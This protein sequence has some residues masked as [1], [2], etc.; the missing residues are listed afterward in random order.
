MNESSTRKGCM[1][2]RL[3]RTQKVMAKDC[4][5]S[6]QKRRA[7]YYSG[8]RGEVSLLFILLLLFLPAFSAASE[9]TDD[10]SLGNS[11]LAISTTKE[12][13][14]LLWEEKDLYTATKRATS[15]RKAPAIATIITA[16]EIRNMGA[17]NLEDVLK[18]V[19]GIGISTNAWGTHMIEVRGIRSGASEKI[20]FMI[21]GHSLN[22][23]T[24][25]SSL[26][27]NVANKLPVENIQH[28]HS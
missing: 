2:K 22:R 9:G 4:L 24:N 5:S 21:A 15:L 19:P 14:L 26:I 25:G 28:H 23:N 20:L 11:Q 13:F 12:V 8:D 1:M 27:Y 7:V 10:N 17:R 16:D 18:M 6:K 3:K